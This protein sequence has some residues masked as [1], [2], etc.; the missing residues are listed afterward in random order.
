MY[1]PINVKGYNFGTYAVTDTATMA[2]YQ[3]TGA[4][5]KTKGDKLWPESGY[6]DIKAMI[7]TQMGSFDFDTGSVVSEDA[8]VLIAE[9]RQNLTAGEY[10]VTDNIYI[11]GVV[12]TS[13]VGTLRTITGSGLKPNERT[14]LYVS[15]EYKGVGNTD[16]Y[17]V[18]AFES[19]VSAGSHLTELRQQIILTDGT[20]LLKAT[21]TIS[22]P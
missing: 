15:D 21:K 14:M 11:A 12:L 1:G 9:V 6:H 2:I 3:A 13:S 5:L 4:N 16:D 22:Y 17:G 18:I 8:G 19:T 7:G 20:G 10:I